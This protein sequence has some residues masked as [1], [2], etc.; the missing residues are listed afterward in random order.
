MF[1]Y[2]SMRNLSIE[3]KFTNNIILAKERRGI[4]TKVVKNFHDM[5]GFHN[6]FKSVVKGV[7]RLEVNYESAL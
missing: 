6:F 1:R 3:N 7:D 4:F 5:S 2:Q